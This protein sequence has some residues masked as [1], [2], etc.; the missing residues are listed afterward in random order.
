MFY[1]V[2]WLVRVYFFSLTDFR[3]IS[4][5]CVPVRGLYAMML[6]KTL[7]AVKFLSVGVATWVAH[8]DVSSQEGPQHGVPSFPN[9]YPR[10]EGLRKTKKGT[11]SWAQNL[12]NNSSCQDTAWLYCYGKYFIHKAL[13]VFSEEVVLKTVTLF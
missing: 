11:A 5:D 4:L 7:I 2:E 12:F 10:L 9:K 3:N 13:F 6:C 1:Q 8:F